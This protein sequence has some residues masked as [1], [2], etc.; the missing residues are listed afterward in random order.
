VNG[1]LRLASAK[2]QQPSLSMANSALRLVSATLNNHRSGL[3]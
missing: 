3:K 2:A 1:A